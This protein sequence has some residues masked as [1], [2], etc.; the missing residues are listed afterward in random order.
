MKANF[1][2][3]FT[4]HHKMN[5]PVRSRMQDGV[6]LEVRYLQLP[7]YMHYLL[8]LRAIFAL[9]PIN[10]VPDTPSS[11]LEYF[12]ALGLLNKMLPKLA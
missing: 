3:L 12:K 7:Y 5:H 9:K 4:I 1:S 6:G 2:E 8:L 10:I 11:T